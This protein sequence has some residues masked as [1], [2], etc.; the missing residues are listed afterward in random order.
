MHV[1]HLQALKFQHYQTFI[2][3]SYT[4]LKNTVLIIICNSYSAFLLT[5]QSFE[6]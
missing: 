2:P 6:L 5:A 3:K 1:I 4:I